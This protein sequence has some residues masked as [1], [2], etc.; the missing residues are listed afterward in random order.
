MNYYEVALNIERYYKKYLNIS[1]LDLLKK[2]IILIKDKKDEEI[3]IDIINFLNG[4]MKRIWDDTLTN[5]KDFDNKGEFK[6]LVK[7]YLMLIPALFDGYVGDSN[8][9]MYRIIS[10][11]D[12][13]NKNIEE[14]GTIG[15][16]QFNSRVTPILPINFKEN[17]SVM[18]KNAKFVSDAY[19]CIDIKLN[20]Y[21]I[22]KDYMKH[23]ASS[24]KKPTVFID[25]IA[26]RKRQGLQIITKE[27]IEKLLYNFMVFY[28]ENIGKNLSISIKKKIISDI[29]SN[30]YKIVLDYF[31]KYY[32]NKVTSDDLLGFVFD[33]FE[34][35][36]LLEK[37]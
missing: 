8:E 37:K 22:T 3:D 24:E 21:D 34:N 28:E 18:V 14:F 23:I 1:E 16:F 11:K 30:E 13:K 4:I 35:K 25:K 27:D 7:D 10:D 26:Y 2:I 20:D 12:I 31:L 5:Y 6:F 15:R 17:K 32:N 29:L 33:L 36:M 19:Y 9:F